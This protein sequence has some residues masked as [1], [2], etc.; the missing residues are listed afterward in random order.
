MPDLTPDSFGQL[1][2]HFKEAFSAAGTTAL[3]AYLESCDATEDVL[4]TA[5]GNVRFKMRSDK[6]FLTPFGWVR[7]ERR[8]YQSDAGDVSF[9]P[10]DEK[11]DMRNETL[12]PIVREAIHFATGHNTPQ[13][14]EDLLSKCALFTPSRTAMLHANEGFGT[15]WKQHG[16][17]ILTTVR[18][19]EVVPVTTK[20]VVV[21]LDGVNVLMHEKGKK[22]GRKRQ[23]PL[24]N[25]SEETP[26]SYQNAMVGSVS[27]Y[28]PPAKEEKGPQRLSSRYVAR[29]PEQEFPEFKTALEVEVAAT[30]SKLP[31][32]CHKMVIVDGSRGLWS[33]VKGCS[34]YKRCLALVDYWHATEY[35]AKAAEAAYGSATYDGQGWF[36]KNKEKLLTERG[37]AM[38][39]LRAMSYLLKSKNPKGKRRTDLLA[40]RRFFRNN[41]KR[42]NYAWFHSRGLPVGSGVVEAA[43]K[44]VVKARMCRSGMRWTKEGGQTVL[45]LRSVI[46]SNRWEACWSEYQALRLVA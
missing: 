7:V 9:V 2:Q 17:R 3:K 29:M 30:F 10:L 35:L 6:E 13:E 1:V 11:W 42:M 14:V 22:R 19:K 24:E 43:C 25:P 26:T 36:R 39:V 12:T 21:S 40:A 4:A 27:L 18:E 28:R 8:L 23:R 37:A 44:S 15:F 32:R 46:K 33:Y 38:K 45:S 41:L 20:A 34:L 5:L 16:E 31:P